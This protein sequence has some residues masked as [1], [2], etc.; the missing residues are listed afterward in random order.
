MRRL[1]LV[2]VGFMGRP[3]LEAARD[4]GF[5]VRVVETESWSGEVPAGVELS[6]VDGLGG[7]GWALDEL[8]AVGGYAL[9]ESGVDGVLGFS[10]PQVLGAAV[11]ADRLGLPSPSLHASALSRNKALQRGC[12]AAHGLPQPG[13]HVVAGHDRAVE[14]AGAGFPVVVKPLSAFGST[15][16]RLVRDARE[17][18]EVLAARSGERLLVER[19]LEGP[20]YSWEGFVRDG[21]VLF[22]NT[23][24]KETTGPPRFVEVAH[25]AGHRFDDAA[26]GA[27]V[28]E[29]AEGVV[30]AARVRT[31]LVHLEF[32]LTAGG[33][34]IMEVAVRTPG[35][36]ILDL[37]AATYR[38]DPY[39]VAVQLA[40][41][42]E[43][44]LP[45]HPEPVSH[46]AAWF[47]ICPPGVV[48]AAEGLDEVLALPHVARAGLAV[49]VGDV[50]APLTSSDQRA[51]Y[52]LVDA[53]SPEEREAA[54]AGARELLRVT[55]E[56]QADPAR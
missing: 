1:G 35:D 31:G 26:T 34:A 52:V 33:P 42:V 11:V 40:M 18:R 30:R 14:W 54:L 25:R 4:L 8:W 29:L 41:G 44:D 49:S 10:E 3:Y 28:R 45:A 21:E 20:E 39:R 9:A 32:R 6:R 7:D 16:V 12:F 17:L 27:A 43:P 37:V 36:F 22:A 24:A 51:G 19:A 56:P 5:G 55:T 15:G 38:F 47:P 2:G 48:T 13:F 23:T 46:A 53:P 50:V